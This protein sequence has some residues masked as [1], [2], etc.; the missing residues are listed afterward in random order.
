MSTILK[1]LR[2]LEREKSAYEA[3]PL[4]DEIAAADEPT[5]RSRFPFGAVLGA[6][7]ALSLGLGASLVWL[8]PREG[9]APVV[10]SAP[11]VPQPAA[12]APVSPSAP[13]VVAA[14]PVV[15]APPPAP[16]LEQPAP[17]ALAEPAAPVAAAPP[18][19][20]F[21]S[22]VAVIERP[23]PPPPAAEPAPTPL[24][25]GV[26]APPAVPVASAAAP[27]A[28]GDLPPS[29]KQG[30]VASKPAPATAPAQPIR[31]KPPTQTQ[32]LAR[33]NVPAV[34]VSSTVWHPERDRRLAKVTFEGSAVRELHE[35]D[36]IGPLVVSKIEP[37][38]VIFLHDGVELRRRVGAKN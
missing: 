37:S 35:G 11:V 14:Q 20:A 1:A 29:S 4:Q 30:R 13:P 31:R 9:E 24:A 25:D 34:F 3:R 6:I 22:P 15:P 32:T 12:P 36:S 7:A 10:A 28:P 16:V 19:E 26:A 8:A 21:S 27:P 33:A 5:S 18:P 2:R 17:V 23:P 38:G